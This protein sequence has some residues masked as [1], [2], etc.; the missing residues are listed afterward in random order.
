[1]ETVFALLVVL[2]VDL[3]VF[4]ALGAYIGAQKG[5]EKAEGWILGGTFGPFGV[6][7]VALL[8]SIPQAR[9]SPTRSTRLGSWPGEY[10]EDWDRP[11][12]H[13]SLALADDDAAEAAEEQAAFDYLTGLDER[14]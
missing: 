11:K 2:V 12:V 5:R 9:P 1:M 3:V 13:P 10:D 4:G 6:L 14:R 7:L 8:P